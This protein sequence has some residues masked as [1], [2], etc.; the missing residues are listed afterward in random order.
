VLRIR[1]VYAGSRILIISYLGSGVSDPR[2]NNNKKEGTKISFVFPFSKRLLKKKFNV[3]TGTVNTVQK[4]LSQVFL[5]KKLILNFLK[6]GLKSWIRYPGSGKKHYPSPVPGVKK[7]HRIPD[8]QHRLGLARLQIFL[9][10][11]GSSLRIWA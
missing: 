5:P 4:I 9:S 7:P 10:G 8:P 1:D 11:S 2:C 6:Y 3:L